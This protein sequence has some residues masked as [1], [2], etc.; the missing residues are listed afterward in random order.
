MKAQ[1]SDGRGMKAESGGLLRNTVIQ[2]ASA[3]IMEM[4]APG[5]D[6]QVVD[7]LQGLNTPIMEMS[8]PGVDG[9]LALAGYANLGDYSLAVMPT[10]S[11]GRLLMWKFEETSGAVAND[12]SG[13][14]NHGAYAGSYTLNVGGGPAAAE[15]SFLPNINSPSTWGPARMLDTAPAATYPFAMMA[16]IHDEVGGTT[17]RAFAD[18]YTGTTFQWRWFRRSGSLGPGIQDPGGTSTVGYVGPSSVAGSNVSLF[19]IVVTGANSVYHMVAGLPYALMTA[20]TLAQPAANSRLGVG[21]HPTV[22]AARLSAAFA[23]YEYFNGQPSWDNLYNFWRASRSGVPTSAEGGPVH[24]YKKVLV[25]Q[26]GLAAVGVQGTLWSASSNWEL[27]G[28]QSTDWSMREN[29]FGMSNGPTLGEPPIDSRFI[30]SVRYTGTASSVW[31]TGLDP[32]VDSITFGVAFKNDG[33]S[34][35]RRAIWSAGTGAAGHLALYWD[36]TTNDIVFKA[37][38]TGAITTN[39]TAAAAMVDNTTF[40]FVGRLDKGTGNIALWINGVKIGETAAPAMSAG[41]ARNPWVTRSPYSTLTIFNGRGWA[42]P[43]FIAKAAYS[44]TNCAILSTPSP[45]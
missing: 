37:E 38:G 3:P 9:E 16:L 34:T 40:W 21:N 45:P 20:R 10:V 42:T 35:I 13:N 32:W 2:A 5:N 8:A 17:N 31:T 24:F 44:D 12:S 11:S 26:L 29:H 15:K 28:N 4:L 25:D 1:F 36:T 27:T 30:Y 22:N 7:V 41:T 33:A 23:H 43:L 14:A 6:A 39:V 18:V 19:G